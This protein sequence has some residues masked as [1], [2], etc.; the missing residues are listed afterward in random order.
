MEVHTIATR[1]TLREIRKYLVNP[2]IKKF[3]YICSVIMLLAGF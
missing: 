3:Y 2:K 1:D